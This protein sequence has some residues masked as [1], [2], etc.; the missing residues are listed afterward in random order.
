MRLAIPLTAV[1][2]VLVAVDARLAMSVGLTLHGRR[3]D[4]ELLATGCPLARHYAAQ[5]PT[6]RPKIGSANGD[7]TGSQ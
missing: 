6:M 7:A 2:I 5:R 1:A 4:Q 3:D